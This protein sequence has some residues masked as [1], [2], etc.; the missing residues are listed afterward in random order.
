MLF[1]PCPTAAL[2]SATTGAGRGCP[3]LGEAKGGVTMMTAGQPPNKGAVSRDVR[4]VRNELTL[5]RNGIKP[6][7]HALMAAGL[8]I[9]V[10]IAKTCFLV[11]TDLPL[12]LPIKVVLVL[13]A[14][15]M[16]A[17]L[18]RQRVPH[19]LRSKGWGHDDTP[20]PPSRV[21][22]PRET[23]DRAAH[24]TPLLAVSTASPAAGGPIGQSLWGWS[25]RRT[26]P[27]PPSPHPQPVHGLPKPLMAL[28]TY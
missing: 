18:N 14:F 12:F 25:I 1:N 21:P 11:M 19:P 5:K 28:P 15:V 26:Q 3:I 27:V 20:P 10:M 23:Q 22:L 8:A 7:P 9:V 13:L 6:M 2:P 24:P 17:T 16:L 4:N